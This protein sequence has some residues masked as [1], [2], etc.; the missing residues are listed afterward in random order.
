MLFSVSI[1]LVCPVPA[2]RIKYLIILIALIEE[3]NEHKEEKKETQH[4]LSS[5]TYTI[6]MQFLI[7]SPREHNEIRHQGGRS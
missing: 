7:L 5:F 1:V 3:E 4:V 2:T 6:H